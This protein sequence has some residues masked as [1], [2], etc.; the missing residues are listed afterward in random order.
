MHCTVQNDTLIKALFKLI[1]TI[2]P[3]KSHMF[4]KYN[5][6]YIYIAD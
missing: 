4:H 1:Y 5:I 6:Q 3:I 2:L